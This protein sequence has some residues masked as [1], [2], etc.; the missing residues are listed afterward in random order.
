MKKV[1]FILF[2]FILPYTVKAYSSSA[3]STIVMDTDNNRI[4]YANNVH[5]VRSVASISKI[6]TA[7]LAIESGKLEEK[8]EVGSEINGAYGS[9]IYISQGE[10][11]TLKDLVYGLML[12]SGNDASYVIANHVGGSIKN[13]VDLMNKKA[14]E[15]GMKNTS[16]NNPNG[17]DDN[18]GNIS[19]AY[20]MALLSSYAIK[21]DIYKKVVNTR[22]Y[23]LKTNKNVYSWTNKNKLLNMYEYA[24]GGKTGYTDIAKRTLVTNASK[25]NVNLTIVTLND[26]DDFNDHIKLYEE[27]FN[28]Y[29]NYEIL[30]EGYL[31]L[32]DEKYYPNR[33]F[34]IKENFNY[35]LND[36]EKNHIV[37]KFYLDKKIT[38]NDGDE[39]GSVH[40]YIGDKKVFETNLY[41]E[42]K[43]KKIRI[44]DIILGWFK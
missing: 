30:K 38:Y 17:L 10:I 37:L 24:V 31:E 29:N 32:V 33:R 22:K 41:V 19:T 27:A 8:I 3:T 26:G 15:I 4:I 34:F 25:N 5:K 21:N 28:E 18:G 39:I 12:R 16:F 14:K 44:I 6:M 23:N 2:L 1:V 20:D 43:K 7:I 40:V 35:L 42:L 36:N 11:L 13:F 9:A